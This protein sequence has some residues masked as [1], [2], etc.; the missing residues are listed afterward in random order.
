MSFLLHYHCIQTT[1]QWA[2]FFAMNLSCCKKIVV[3]KPMRR[4]IG[5]PPNATKR[6]CLEKNVYKIVKYGRRLERESPL[7][8]FF[9]QF[10]SQ[11]CCGLAG[12]VVAAH[13]LFAD[14]L[15]SCCSRV[16][17]GT[18][19]QFSTVRLFPKILSPNLWELAA[20]GVAAHLLSACGLLIRCWRFSLRVG[21]VGRAFPAG[22]PFLQSTRPV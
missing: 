22:P 15:W 3:E 5:F 1:W 2:V 16:R 4:E 10:F 18:G 9:P 6:C 8:A 14:F 7:R 13:H 11:N 12:A 19:T 21:C 17:P 20:A